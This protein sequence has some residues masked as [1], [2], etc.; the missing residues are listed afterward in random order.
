MALKQNLGLT[1]FSR[2]TT[3]AKISADIPIIFLVETEELP[4][5]RMRR[6][7]LLAVCH[8]KTIISLFLLFN[9]SE[10]WERWR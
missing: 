2:S 6:W 7:I 5:K 4:D 3:K 1:P 9:C 10:G 8:L